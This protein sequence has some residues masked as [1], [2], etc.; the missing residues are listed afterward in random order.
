MTLI[1]AAERPAIA[2]L[3][4]M[5]LFALSGCANGPSRCAIEEAV[6]A[7]LRQQLLQLGSSPLAQLSGEAGELKELATNEHLRVKVSDERC[8][9]IGEDKFRCDVLLDLRGVGSLFAAGGADS[10]RQAVYVLTKLGGKWRA[11]EASP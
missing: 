4:G 7:D 5:A 3:L 2:V 11:Q 8:N 10:E 6:S 9:P 1:R